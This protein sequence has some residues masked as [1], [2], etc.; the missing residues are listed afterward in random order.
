MANSKDYTG[1]EFN[2]CGNKPLFYPND[3]PLTCELIKELIERK[4][5]VRR[6]SKYHLKHREVNYYPST[7]VITIDGRGRHPETGPD[8]FL[9]LL[10]GEY[11]RRH[12]E[13]SEAH[14]ASEELRPSGLILDINLDREDD[15]T[16]R[17][18]NRKN[19]GEGDVPW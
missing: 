2:L 4:R 11:P 14:A 16:A 13:E 3:D 9:E 1:S 5:Y 6:P 12:G 7:K 15:A 19:D 10:D 8:A 17:D 18:H